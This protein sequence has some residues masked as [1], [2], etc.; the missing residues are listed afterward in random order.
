MKKQ[1]AWNTPLKTVLGDL[2][3]EKRKTENLALKELRRRFVGLDKKEQVLVLMC[4]LRRERSYRAWAYSRLLDLWDDVFEPVIIDLWN[5]FHEERCAW[6]IVRHFPISFILEHKEELSIGRNRPF[7]VRRLCED[8]SY[9]ID[10]NSLD[11]Y[12]Y[13]WVMSSTGRL[14]S[15]N[16][17][18]SLLV[19]VTK[20][21]CEKKYTADYVNGETFSEKLNKMLYHIDKMGMTSVAD[22]Y[23]NWYHKS[24]GGI[25]DK[26]LWNLYRF[27][28]QFHF[29]GINHPYDF[30]AEKLAR[31]ID[32]LNNE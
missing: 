12:E 27:S 25:T 2:K 11:P 13:L 28:T 20:D 31:N 14:I 19:K 5:A 26:Q 6:P 1:N 3:S 17:L 7:V 10:N 29:E 24:L 15:A 23:R 16:E 32:E 30:L 9:E 8:K 22:R 18:W 21:I 4:H